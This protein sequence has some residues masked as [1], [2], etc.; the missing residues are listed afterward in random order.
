MKMCCAVSSH[1]NRWNG[2]LLIEID[3]KS[4]QKHHQLTKQ[5]HQQT[6]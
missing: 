3:V 1:L 2:E 4:A 5:Q 6:R